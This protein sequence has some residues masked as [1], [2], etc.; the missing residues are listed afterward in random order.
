ML[1]AMG[2]RS[3]AASTT[4]VASTGT[5]ARRRVRSVETR[6]AVAVAVLIG[7][8]FLTVGLV[9][10]AAGATSTS[11]QMVDVGGLVDQRIVQTVSG[12]VVALIA[13]FHLMATVGVWRLRVGARD[14]LLTM[15]VL[16]SLGVP[17]AGLMWVYATDPWLTTRTALAGTANL[18]LLW[19][20]TRPAQRADVERADAR[21][22]GSLV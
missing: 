7:G 10:V 8:I 19:L 5:T 15:T 9:D 4:R 12:G 3:D 6:G 18:V 22:R 13:V 20:L 1:A 2:T 11:R 14:A 16:F 21:R 17:L